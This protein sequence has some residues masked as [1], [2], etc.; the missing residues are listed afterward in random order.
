ML[1]D[2][3]FFEAVCESISNCWTTLHQISLHKGAVE[4]AFQA[5]NS[6][7]C[8][9]GMRISSAASWV[10]C[11]TG[12]HCGFHRSTL[13]TPRIVQSTAQ[14]SV[15]FCMRPGIAAILACDCDMLYKAVACAVL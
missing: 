4:Y 2:R 12:A 6:V 13:L 5:C 10:A 14:V 1:F 7:A 11:L 9:V 3:P 15:F 8:G